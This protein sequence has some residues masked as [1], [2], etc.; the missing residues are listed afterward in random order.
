VGVAAGV[1]VA[2]DE[3][4]V[5]TE[6]LVAQTSIGTTTNHRIPGRPA[7]LNRRCSAPAIGDDS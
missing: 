6:Q 4:V 2:A 5:R 7:N 3:P 1:V